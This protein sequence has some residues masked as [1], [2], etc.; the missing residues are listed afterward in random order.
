ML[1]A[2]LH[3][4]RYGYSL[5]EKV[6]IVNLR[7]TVYTPARKFSSSD[8]LT[9]DGF[10]N[11]DVT[12]ADSGDAVN[13]LSLTQELKDGNKINGPAVISQYASTTYIAP[14]WQASFDVRGNLSLTIK[15]VD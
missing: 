9:D 10:N 11:F 2:D 13:E 6:E 1:F 8:F 14:R 12:V 7:A 5:K 15:K 3:Q 4:S